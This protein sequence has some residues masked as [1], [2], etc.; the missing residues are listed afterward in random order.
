MLDLATQAERQ[1]DIP[2]GPAFHRTD[3]GPDPGEAIAM[4][5]SDL[6]FPDLDLGRDK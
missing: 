1:D 4:S 2:I 5:E 3:R 6:C